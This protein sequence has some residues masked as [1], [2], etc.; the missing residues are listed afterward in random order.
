VGPGEREVR[1]HE[2][3]IV[4]GGAR[5]REGG[6]ADVGDRFT[7]AE[8]SRIMF[9]SYFIFLSSRDNTN[10][11]TRIYTIRS[12]EIENFSRSN[13]ARLTPRVGSARH[14]NVGKTIEIAIWRVFLSK[15]QYFSHPSAT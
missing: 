3:A 8:K 2:G 12:E 5:G 13:R 7:R 14:L 11:F 6:R 1:R 10:P 4:R 9:V 15:T